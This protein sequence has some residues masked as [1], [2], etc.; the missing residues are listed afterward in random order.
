M[1]T[2]LSTVIAWSSEIIQLKNGMFFFSFLDENCFVQ[3]QCSLC[4][5]QNYET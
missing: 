2:V 1:V 4:Q 3:Q 5:M